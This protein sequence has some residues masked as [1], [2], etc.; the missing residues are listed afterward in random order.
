MKASMFQRKTLI[1]SAMALLTGVAHAQQTSSVTLYGVVDTNVGRTETHAGATANGVGLTPQR[2]SRFGMRGSENIGGGLR[3]LFQLEAATSVPDGTTTEN[4][5]LFN[6]HAWVG[7]GGAFGEIAFGRQETLH[8]VMN[9]SGYN[10][11]SG[12]AELSVTT[13]NSGLQLMQNFGSRINNAVRYTSPSFS[14]VRLRLQSALGHRTTANTN[15]LLLTY[16]AKDLRLAMAYE[17]RDGAGVAGIARWNE[18]LTVGGQY[19]FGPATL[20]L[21]YQTTDK[22]STAT[23]GS[24]LP[25]NAAALPEHSAYNIGLIVPVGKL[26]L[27]GQ[28]TQSTTNTPAVGS[29]AASSRDYTRLGLSARYALS[30]RTYVYG[31]YNERDVDVPTASANKNS[32]GLGV[33]HNF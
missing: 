16:N 5:Q 20:A 30:N 2:G 31:A 10:D 1:L 12:E 4:G 22:L 25:T 3:G 32:L 33:S 15:G 29:T 8:R 26:T 17:Y 28:Y 11:V 18:V 24:T 21:G 14:G 13:A 19:N 7:I 23:S 27:R 9:T 6:R